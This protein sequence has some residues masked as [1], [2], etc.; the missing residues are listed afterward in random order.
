MY[1]TLMSAKMLVIDTDIILPLPSPSCGP[2]E[3]FSFPS[4]DIC[5]S[6]IL[7]KKI[8]FTLVLRILWFVFRKDMESYLDYLME[9]GNFVSFPTTVIHSVGIDAQPVFTTKSHLGD[10]L[11]ITPVW[12]CSAGAANA[13]AVR[14]EWIRVTGRREEAGLSGV[15]LGRKWLSVLDLRHTGLGS[16]RAHRPQMS[17]SVG[18]QGQERLFYAFTLN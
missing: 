8:R 17:C 15:K 13:R 7:L 16:A 2:P 14:L 5:R 12:I 18:S 1:K 9:F 10:Y 6:F 4:V 3:S 11:L